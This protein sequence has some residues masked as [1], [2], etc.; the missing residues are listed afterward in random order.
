MGFFLAVVSR[1]CSLVG[2]LQ[3]LIP[4]PSLVAEHSLQSEEAQQ[5]WLTGLVALCHV[6]SSRIRDQ[7]HVPYFDRW[8]LNHWTTGE[9]LVKRFWIWKTKYNEI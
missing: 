5:L 4:V 3:L 9:V 8:F 6:E 2:V 1:D 7:T